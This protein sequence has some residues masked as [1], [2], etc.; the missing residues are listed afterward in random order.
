[1][2]ISAFCEYEVSYDATFAILTEE[3]TF[4]I[5]KNNWTVK[6]E[7]GELLEWLAGDLTDSDV[8]DVKFN[9]GLITVNKFNPFT[10]ETAEINYKYKL[11]QANKNPVRESA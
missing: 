7:G 9:D 6:A 11:L 8:S 10:G 1:M 3:N 5:Q 2:V 4:D